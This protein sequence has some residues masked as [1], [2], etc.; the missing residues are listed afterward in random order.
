VVKINLRETRIWKYV[1]SGHSLFKVWKFVE[2]LLSDLLLAGGII[3][4]FVEFHCRLPSR[5]RSSPSHFEKYNSPDGI[6]TQL[7][8]TLE[9]VVSIESLSK[10]FYYVLNTYYGQRIRTRRKQ[11]GGDR[12]VVK[13]GKNQKNQKKTRLREL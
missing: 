2:Y 5:R 11:S 6:R 8:G 10:I 7:V 13:G 4:P 9:L 3:A 12:D 1:S